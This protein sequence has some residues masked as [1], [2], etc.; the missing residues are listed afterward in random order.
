MLKLSL[1]LRITNSRRE[2]LR[3]ELHRGVEVHRLLGAG[4]GEAWQTAHPGFDI[5]R[6]P[7]WIAL[8][9]PVGLDAMLRAN[10]FGPNDDV[11]CVAGL[12]SEQPG[13]SRLTRLVQKLAETTGGSLTDVAAVWFARYLQAVIDPVLWLYR[14]YGIALEAHQ[15]NTL[16]VLD[17][18]GW[19][20]GGRYRDNQGYYFVQ[21]RI[22]ELEKL[23]PDVGV[24]SDTTVPDDVAEERLGY[25]LGIN[26]LL[27]WWARSGRRA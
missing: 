26:N 22:G 21:T 14:T 19:P 27:G 11:W 6:D 24:V 1:G 25:Y 7:A 9:G 2:N 20:A 16:V 3:K 4:I 10:P 18:D 5:V 8:D 17:S 12:T 13:P 23:L 15:Q